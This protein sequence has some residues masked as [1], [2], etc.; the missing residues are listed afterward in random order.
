MKVRRLL[1]WVCAISLLGCGQTPEELHG[2][3][4]K[5]VSEELF[6]ETVVWLNDK[7]EMEQSTR[8]VTR[9]EQ[10]AQAAARLAQQEGRTAS[11]IS[12]LI[13]DCNNPNSLWLLDSEGSTTGWKLCLYKDPSQAIGAIDLS[14]VVYLRFSGVTLYWNGRVRSLWAGNSGGNLAQC[15]LVRNLCYTGTAPYVGFR[16]GQWIPS[17]A[18]D[19][20]L[21]TAWLSIYAP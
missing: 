4:G 7:G 20:R 5:A 16:A 13:I 2:D 6:G 12:S 8:F 21:N 18:A 9:A 11:Q 15:D 17:I 1:P 3:D 19:A 10:E 14:K